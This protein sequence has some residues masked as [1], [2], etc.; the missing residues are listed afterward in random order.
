LSHSRSGRG[1]HKPHDQHGVL[2]LQQSLRLF[3][4]GYAATLSIACCGTGVLNSISS[5]LLVVA[6]STER[7]SNDIAR[8]PHQTRIQPETTKM[9]MAL[10]IFD[11]PHWSSYSNCLVNDDIFNL[12]QKRLP[13]A[14]LSSHI[15]IIR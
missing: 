1:S 5:T 3:Q 7:Q 10:H 9:V 2:D 14:D 12:R 8:G 15:F 4:T 6:W 11:S 13:S